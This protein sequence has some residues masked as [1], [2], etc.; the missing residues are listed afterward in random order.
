MNPLAALLLIP[1]DAAF[2]S[3]EQGRNEGEEGASE[4]KCWAGRES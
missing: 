1:A 4:R 3:P 2:L